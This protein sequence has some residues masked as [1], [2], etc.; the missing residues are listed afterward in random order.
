MLPLKMCY[1]SLKNREKVVEVLISIILVFG[2][3]KVLA[4]NVEF[5]G[6][7]WSNTFCVSF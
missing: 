7:S 5:Q 3:F 4:K 1:T 6:F 2:E